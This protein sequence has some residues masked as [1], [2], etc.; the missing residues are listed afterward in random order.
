MTN[1]HLKLYSHKIAKT[2]KAWWY[3]ENGGINIVVESRPETTQYQ[4]SWK[5]LRNALA[6]KDK[7]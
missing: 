5:A 6:R 3:E 7:K 1:K 4:I 2:K